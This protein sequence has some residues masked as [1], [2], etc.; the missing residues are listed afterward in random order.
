VH[1]PDLD[2]CALAQAQ[3]VQAILVT[4]CEELDS[5][6]RTVFADASPMLLEV[7]VK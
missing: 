7:R 5:A 2:F 6:L 4:R 3:G 1:L